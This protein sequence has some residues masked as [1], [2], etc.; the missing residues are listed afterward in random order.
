MISIAGIGLCRNSSCEHKDICVR[1][2]AKGI[3]TYE[4]K[5]IC[6]KENKYQWLWRVETSIVKK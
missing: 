1:Y 5:N 4:F 3:D 6:N 2:L